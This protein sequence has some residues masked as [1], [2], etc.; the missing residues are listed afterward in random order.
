MFDLVSLWFGVIFRIFR[1]HRDLMVENLALR[2][3][4]AVL[5]RKHPTPKLL[6]FA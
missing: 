1:T 3:Q 2:Q 6:T 5:K 4:L